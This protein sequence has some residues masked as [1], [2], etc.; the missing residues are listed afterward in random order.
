MS[1]L[2]QDYTVT[3]HRDGTV[4]ANGGRKVGT[5]RAAG[6]SGAGARWAFKG[7]DDGRTKLARTREELEFFAKEAARSLTIRETEWF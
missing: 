2:L 3:F 1:L 7:D 4:T 6:P 5:Y